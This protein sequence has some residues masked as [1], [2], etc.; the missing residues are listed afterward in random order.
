MFWC[1]P[2][3]IK[4]T[5]RNGPA[6]GHVNYLKSKRIILIFLPLF[7]PI[8]GQ[9]RDQYVQLAQQYAATHMPDETGKF[10]L[11]EASAVGGSMT[12]RD[13]LMDRVSESITTCDPWPGK[14]SVT[15]NLVEAIPHIPDYNKQGGSAWT[16]T[17]D[18]R[19]FADPSAAVGDPPVYTVT[20][21]DTVDIAMPLTTYRTILLHAGCP[22]GFDE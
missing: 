10:A 16:E 6:S 17:H 11:L 20:G 3:R 7:L 2:V 22:D 1:Y 9:G 12:V 21:D 4:L 5:K 15:F 18:L 19:L 13:D 8:M 14:I